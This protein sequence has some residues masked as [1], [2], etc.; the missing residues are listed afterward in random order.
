MSRWITP[1]LIVS[2]IACATSEELPSDDELAELD[3]WA[4]TTDGK[5]DLPDTWHEL[6]AWLRD[7]YKNKMSAVWNNQPHPTSADA[8]LAQIRDLV[9]AAG[10]DP[11]TTKFSTTVQ[12]LVA[13]VDH[14]EINIA[15][16]GGK[17]VRLVGDPKGAGVFFDRALFKVP[18]GPRLCLTWTELETAVRTAYV[19]GAYAA[20]YV[21]HTVTERV[22]RALD[23]GTARY[24]AQFRTYA[25]ARWIWGPAPPSL[26]SHDP[27]D[28][29]VSRSCD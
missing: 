24:A 6:V 22:L 9:R 13:T 25:S 29:R 16:P 12:K 8:A 7:V 23:V 14:S 15:L 11:S 20:T 10:R 27:Q 4:T 21:C 3:G 26:N 19:E 5:A 28:W 1:L 2:L 17:V 18:V